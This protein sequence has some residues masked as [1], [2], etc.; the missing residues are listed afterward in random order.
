MRQRLGTCRQIARVESI[1]PVVGIVANILTTVPGHIVPLNQH[2]IATQ[3]SRKPKLVTHEVISRTR[4][5]KTTFKISTR[6]VSTL[7]VQWIKIGTIEFV[8]KEGQGVGIEAFLGRNFPVSD[9]T[10]LECK[11]T[12]VMCREHSLKNNVSTWLVTTLRGGRQES[13]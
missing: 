12:H 11:M 3:T 5:S 4:A 6:D 2:E 13:T 8:L 1:R 7:W 9:G 10:S